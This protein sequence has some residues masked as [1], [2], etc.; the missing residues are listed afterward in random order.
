MFTSCKK[1][2]FRGTDCSVT[3]CNVAFTKSLNNAVNVTTALP[4][5]KLLIQSGSKTD[6]FNEPDGT[7]KYS[8]APVLLTEINNRLPFTFSVKVNPAFDTTYDAGALYI[9]S[10]DDLWH[11]F[12]FEMDER[13]FTRLVTVKTTG[14]SDDNNH[15]RVNEKSVFMKIS[16]DTRSVGFYYS[17]DSLNWQLVR[18]YKNNYPEKT[19]IGISSQS[20]LGKGIKTVFENCRMSKEA[21]KNFRSGI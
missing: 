20:P 8:N 17:T 6:F 21:V 11:K 19:W 4:E 3:F 12:A 15:E 13:K 5:D 1:T 18:V 2:P 10:N 7:A 16:S 9:Y 14:T